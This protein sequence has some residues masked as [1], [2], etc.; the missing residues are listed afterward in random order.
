MK[1]NK[2]EEVAQLYK[3]F[4]ELCIQEA[5]ALGKEERGRYLRE[6]KRLSLWDRLP[7]K[8]AAGR[9]INFVELL[10]LKG[11][12]P[13]DFIEVRWV[14]RRPLIY[15]KGVPQPKRSEPEGYDL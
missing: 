10:K 3:K 9:K 13:T 6:Y 11:V 2:V 1:K 12:D 7:V 15:L 14:N 4:I 8:S 5:E